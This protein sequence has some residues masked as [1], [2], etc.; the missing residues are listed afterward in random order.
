M[1]GAACFCFFLLALW[2][3]S[4]SLSNGDVTI[5]YLNLSSNAL[6]SASG[7]HTVKVSYTK[8]RFQFWHEK[9]RLYHMYIYLR[10][11][12]IAANSE[13]RSVTGCMR[14]HSM[15]SFLTGKNPSF[16]H[17]VFV[18]AEA[19]L[20]S[21]HRRKLSRRISFSKRPPKR[22]EKAKVLLNAKHLQLKYSARGVSSYT[23][24][25]VIL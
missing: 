16:R 4:T 12:R 17:C 11:A 9:K 1:C 15:G 14:P 8:V 25:S 20:L 3:D 7:R 5:R 21:L 23:T 6:S 18:K 24:R 13:V 2:T 19:W 10:E 22:R